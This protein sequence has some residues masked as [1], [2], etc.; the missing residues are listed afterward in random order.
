MK[1]LLIICLL[2]ALT[3][4][5]LL[6]LAQ[7][8]NKPADA[9]G[10][11]AGAALDTDVRKYSYAI[12][13]QWARN[14]AEAEMDV[15]TDAM[16]RGMK[17][18]LA[19]ARAAKNAGGVVQVK[20]TDQQIG[21]AIRV[22]EDMMRQKIEARAADLRRGAAD[23]NLKAGKLFLADNAKK[24]GVKATA[25]GLQYKVL[26]QGEGA[27]PTADDRVTVHYTGK[28]IDGTVFDSS[29]NRGQPATFPVGG[30]IK[31]WTEALQ[32][33][34]KGAQYRLFIPADLAYGERGAGDRIGPNAV[35]IFDVE[36]LDIKKGN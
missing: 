9:P 22:F 17:D 18:A 25:S 20:L 28:L 21:D 6:L 36:L 23:E 16:M 31:G 2:L 7:D 19:D 24:E 1:R 26:K 5:P 13:V 32:L 30:V 8:P 10:A 3:G 27:R 15:D 34:S 4:A 33:M 12:G 14:M 29:H 11:P 35:L